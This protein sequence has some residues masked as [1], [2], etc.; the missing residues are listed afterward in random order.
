MKLDLSVIARNKM[1]LL[2]IAIFLV[3]CLIGYNFIYKPGTKKDSQ[4]RLEIS[5]QEEVNRL[6]SEIQ[7]F[8]QKVQSLH[9]RQAA[10]HNTDWL[11]TNITKIAKE[12]EVKISSIQPK[13]SIP[14]DRYVII[15][16]QAS[17]E[18]T[19]HRLGE[20][21]SRLESSKEFIKVDSLNLKPARVSPAQTKGQE[22]P[23][24]EG[25]VVRGVLKVSSFYV[26]P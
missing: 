14:R 12:C 2:S 24:E 17:A 1:A 25:V 9:E 23:F 11:L 16:C 7:Q 15:I 3:A 4:I 20:F 10:E 13:S 26:K 18:S 6:L 5:T 22:S 19:Y 21:I 8:Q